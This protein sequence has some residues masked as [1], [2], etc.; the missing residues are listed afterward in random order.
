MKYQN[1]YPYHEKNSTRQLFTFYCSIMEVMFFFDCVVFYTVQQELHLMTE[2]MHIF[3]NPKA[4]VPEET[5][6]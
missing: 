4:S 3:L 2:I 5:M 6:K 1:A